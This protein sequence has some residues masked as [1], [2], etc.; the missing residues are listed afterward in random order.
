MTTKMRRPIRLDSRHDLSD[1]DCD[2]E[3]LNIWLQRRAL[4]CDASGSTF[5]FVV[6]DGNKVVAYYSF[7]V[8]SVERDV[9][10]ERIAKG[11]PHCPIPILLLARL[12]IDRRQQGQGLGTK[13]MRDFL[14]RAYNIAQESVPLRCIVVDAK[15]DNAKAFYARFDFRP[16]PVDALRMWL[17]V[18]DL[19]R[20]LESGVE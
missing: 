5:T 19:K 18:K 1:F 12:A 10:P 15:D 4:Q 3:Q 9:V 20:T 7:T 8:G 6:V 13:L 17:L 11:M 14:R 16:W 2:N